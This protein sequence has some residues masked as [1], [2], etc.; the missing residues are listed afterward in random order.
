[1]R[2]DLIEQMRQLDSQD[3][4]FALATV[5]DVEGSASARIGSKAVFNHD[6]ENLYGWVGGGC[7]ESFVGE[8]AVAAINEGAPRTILVDL[9]DEVFGLGVKCGGRMRVFVEPLLPPQP[10]DVPRLDP[11]ERETELAFLL[12]SLGLEPRW[13]DTRIA[14]QDLADILMVATH[15]I[16]AARGRSGRSLREM[17]DLPV[18][19]AA[20]TIRPVS[21]AVLIGQTRIMEALARFLVQLGYETTLVAPT[22]D[23]KALPSHVRCVCMTARVDDIPFSADSITVVG[24]HHAEDPTFV[25]RALEAGSPYV[26][27]VGSRTRALEVIDEL[28]IRDRNGL[29]LPLYTPAGLDMDA[30]NPDE[31]AL[32]VV[33]ELISALRGVPAT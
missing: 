6:G 29:E 9:D 2:R 31:I 17:K 25:R 28:G 22:I 15:S 5:I 16:V 14:V 1:M 24:S 19:F 7:A 27:M 10:I 23:E 18:A 30:R 8:N 33:A 11:P 13:K 21:G 32:S 12:G 26:A 20:Q 4:P 3:E